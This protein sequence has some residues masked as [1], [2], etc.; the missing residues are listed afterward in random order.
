MAT[1]ASICMISASRGRT[2]H[3]FGSVHYEGSFTELIGGKL[4]LNETAAKFPLALLGY[5][6]SESVWGGHHSDGV[7]FKFF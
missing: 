2:T 6:T 4:L 7:Q 3:W 5:G 1:I